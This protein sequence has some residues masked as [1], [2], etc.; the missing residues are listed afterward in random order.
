MRPWAAALAPL[1]LTPC[2]GIPLPVRCMCLSR[3]TPIAVK[4]PACRYTNRQLPQQ[5][6]QQQQQHFHNHATG[7]LGRLSLAGA[8]ALALTL[9]GGLQAWLWMEA[10]DHPQCEGSG[11]SD[12]DADDD[13]DALEGLDASEL[14]AIALF[15]EVSD[16]VGACSGWTCQTLL[17][18]AVAGR[19]HACVWCVNWVCA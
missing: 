16:S 2:G 14:Q 3:L 8:L 4:P 12:D 9:A 15:K 11:S 6:Q 7:L 18:R 10:H 5:Q 19:V 17:V 13:D 1:R